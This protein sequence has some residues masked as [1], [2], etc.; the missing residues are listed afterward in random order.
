MIWVASA[1]Y[2]DGHIVEKCFP[3]NEDGNYRL[4][5][6]RQYELEEWLICRAHPQSV[7]TWYSVSCEAE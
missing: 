4:E 3:Y 6:N 1:E 7:P 2:E 5:E